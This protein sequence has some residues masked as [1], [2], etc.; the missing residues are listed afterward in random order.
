MNDLPLEIANQFII[1]EKI[2]GTK[3]EVLLYCETIQDMAE[4]YLKKLKLTPTETNLCS[5]VPSGTLEMEI[6]EFDGPTSTHRGG[7]R[8]SSHGVRKRSR[9]LRSI[10]EDNESDESYDFLE[11]MDDTSRSSF[12]EG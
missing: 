7:K 1:N 4:H 11:Q 8:G 2:T 10:A 6:F 3:D 5:N 9:P 12:S